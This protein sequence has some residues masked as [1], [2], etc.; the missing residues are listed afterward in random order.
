MTPD[1]TFRTLAVPFAVE[2]PFALLVP[3]GYLRLFDVAPGHRAFVLGLIAMVSLIKSALLAALLE[4]MLA[5]VFRWRRDPAR[6]P[7]AVLLRAGE[8]AYQVPARFSVVW[9]ASWGLMYF[10]VTAIAQSS[11]PEAVAFGSSALTATAL[12]SLACIAAALPLAYLLLNWLLTGDAGG[13]SL[14]ARARSLPIPMRGPSLHRRLAVLSVCIAIAP[15]AWIEAIAYVH[16]VRATLDHVET[17]SRVTATR[18]AFVLQREMQL[19][20]RDPRL[21]RSLVDAHRGERVVPFLATVDGEFEQGIAARE[22]LAQSPALASWFA[23]AVRGDDSGMRSDPRLGRAVAFQRL[24]A[25]HVVGAVS[26]ASGAV[27][28]GSLVTL[29]LFALVPLI[30]APFCAAFLAAAIAGPLSRI[31]SMIGSLSR[32]DP[33]HEHTGRIPVFS[34]DEIGSLAENVNVMV[35]AEDERRRF[36]DALARDR[37]QLAA[38]LDEMPIGV[39]VTEAAG[40][41]RYA[42]RRVPAILRTPVDFDHPLRAVRA[43]EPRRGDGRAYAVEELPFMRAILRGETVRGEEVDVRRGD[44]TP[45]TLRVGAA[46]VRDGG[47]V[48]IAAVITLDDVTL[49]KQIEVE[50]ERHAHFRELFLAVLSH[51][52]RNPVST[53]KTGAAFLLRGGLPDG[54]ARITGRMAHAADRMARM[55]DQLLDLTRSRL[56]GGIPVTPRAMDLHECARRVVEEL[57]MA[58][59]DCPIE[60]VTE[61]D[62]RGE[63]DADRLAQ[64]V[65]N[66]VGNAVEHGCV[67]EPVR[68]RVRDEGAAVALEV[69]NDGAPI[70]PELLPVLFDPF[71]RGAV[72]ADGAARSGLGLGLYITQQIVQAHGGTLSVRSTPRDGTTFRVRLP[73]SAASAQGRP[74]PADAPGNVLVRPA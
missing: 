69:H 11:L 33:L 56:G 72:R 61:G 47:G 4:R 74:P 34:P 55:I 40:S 67:D 51:D 65:S 63:W 17:R 70:P 44:G 12:L 15:T 31:S 2:L 19:G 36:T 21:L 35:D 59:P 5:P 10:P 7:D 45:G 62:A 14:A 38:I 26:F 22:L 8:A 3:L 66:L 39:V 68:V 27:P 13:I 20:A 18:L 48:V 30:W 9:A 46:P 29:A 58:Y 50:R 53:V 49:E 57:E 54:P 41:V 28:R 24:G 37:G 60:L 1:S 23:Q 71:R 52:L 64:V 25:R 6:A 16:E 32:E 73:R 42:N 43:L